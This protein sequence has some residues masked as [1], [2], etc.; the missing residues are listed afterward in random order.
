MVDKDDEQNPLQAEILR[1]VA[2]EMKEEQ[3]KQLWKK[4]SPYVMSVVAAALIVTGSIE[5]YKEYQKRRSLDEASQLQAA[6]V[7]LEAKDKSGAEMLKTLSE[8]SDRGYRYLAA[9][10]YTD[11]LTSKGAEK[12]EEAVAVLNRIIEDPQSPEPFKNL[13]LFDKI[14]LQNKN[15]L[16]DYEEA[17]KELNAL[18][19][20]SEAWAPLAFEFAAGLALQQE[21]QEKALSYWKKILASSSVSEEKRAKIAEYAAFVKNGKETATGK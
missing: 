1:E 12:Y 19:E 18:A 15:G 2:E 17:D 14:L 13:A 16:L 5:F 8:T 9:F 21:D 7:R 3:L 6:L 10:H 11:Y 20:K 4:I